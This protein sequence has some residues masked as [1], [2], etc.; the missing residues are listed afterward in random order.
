VLTT[1]VVLVF[2]TGIRA[3]TEHHHRAATPQIWVCGY[4]PKVRPSNI[5][6]AC[7]DD[8][9]GLGNLR[10]EH[11]GEP[12]AIA[13]G[14]TYTLK[15]QVEPVSCNEDFSYVFAPITVE[16]YDLVHGY[17]QRLNGLHENLGPEQSSIDTTPPVPSGHWH[18]TFRVSPSTACASSRHACHFSVP[19]HSAWG[20]AFSW[21]VTNTSSHGGCLAFTPWLGIGDPPKGD[22]P[23]SVLCLHPHS[24]ATFHLEDRWPLFE[25]G[26]GPSKCFYYTVASRAT[27]LTP[28]P[29]DAQ[30]V[31]HASLIW[32]Q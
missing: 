12:T 1:L 18:R 4:Y 16:A 19:G 23:L 6:I 20:E 25:D 30:F 24:S 11:W 5:P 29:S 2:G 13:H 26:D 22:P 27:A 14:K 32:W 9:F 31:V 28:A 3:A 7:G 10:W 17:Y 8:Q 15:C 21:R